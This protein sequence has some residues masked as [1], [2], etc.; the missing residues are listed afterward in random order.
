MKY[1]ISLSL[2]LLV[3]CFSTPDEVKDI[4]IPITSSFYEDAVKFADE[5]ARTNELSRWI[6]IGGAAGALVGF[7]AFVFVPAW[8][9]PKWVSAVSIPMSVGIAVFSHRLIEWLGSDWAGYIVGLSVGFVLINGLAYLAYK[10]WVG[11]KN[12]LLSRKG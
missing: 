10:L 4:D 11:A 8:V 3:G 5:R 9:T 6:S 7:L 2:L 1:L 12:R